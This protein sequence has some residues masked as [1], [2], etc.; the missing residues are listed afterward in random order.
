VIELL[1]AAARGSFPPEDGRT[2]VMG[3]VEGAPAA[4]L[5]FTA[6]HVV[7][8]DVPPA[9]VLARVDPEDLKGPL[10]PAVLTWLAERTGLVAGSLDVVLAW[11]PERV[12]GEAAPV[13]EVAPAAHPRVER[14][15]RWRRELRVFEGEGGMVVLGRGLAGRLELSVE[16]DRE[17]R[18]RGV[19][20]RLVAGALRA[21]AP[22]EPVFAQVAAANAAS[23]RALQPA[24]FAAVGAEVL[25]GPREDFLRRWTD[26]QVAVT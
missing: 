7:A 17:L 24:G 13:R 26:G 4:V 12:G 18:D 15:R 10:A 21:A 16:V 14:A 20:R 2:E 8:A 19:A 22:A 23:L 5:S 1:H 3:A 25:F 6:H 9:E 11:V